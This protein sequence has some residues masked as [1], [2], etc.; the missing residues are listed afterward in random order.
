MVAIEWA[1]KAVGEMGWDIA[2]EKPRK[3][4]DVVIPSGT[5]AG[6]ALE[7]G[8]DLPPLPGGAW[9][10]W[11]LPSPAGND[12]SAVKALAADIEK[13]VEGLLT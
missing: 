2:Y 3:L 13:K 8:L 12:P 7:T 4:A 5:A 9:Q 11:D 10:Y 1:V 6:I